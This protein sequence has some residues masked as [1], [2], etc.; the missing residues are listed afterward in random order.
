MGLLSLSVAIS[1]WG[2]N[3]ERLIIC[4]LAYEGGSFLSVLNSEFLQTDF[5]ERRSDLGQS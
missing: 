2:E 4:I 5:V 3:G 1:Q